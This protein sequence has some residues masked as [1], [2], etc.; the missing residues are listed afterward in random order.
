MT[1]KKLLKAHPQDVDNLPKEKDIHYLIRR[2]FCIP[3]R[4]YYYSCFE[5]EHVYQIVEFALKNRNT[6]LLK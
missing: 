5:G 4:E 2:E 1:I 6:K 3:Y